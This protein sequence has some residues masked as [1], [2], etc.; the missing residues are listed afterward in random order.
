MVS[1]R[2]AMLLSLHQKTTLKDILSPLKGAYGRYEP[3][4]G[5]P[6]SVQDAFATLHTCC[7]TASSSW[8]QIWNLQ[9]VQK[10]G[11]VWQIRWK[12][13]RPA[14]S[15]LGSFIVSHI[16]AECWSYK[17][18]SSQIRQSWWGRLPVCVPEHGVPPVAPSFSN[19]SAIYIFRKV[20][21]ICWGCIHEKANEHISLSWWT[22][23]KALMA[24]TRWTV[25][26][27]CNEALEE[28]KNEQ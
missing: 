10:V 23:T 6:A 2:A 27:V 8:P 12:S 17:T 14:C 16:G 11:G 24:R 21:A 20:R 5:H 25:S 19:A 4:F 7:S 18:L 26:A 3:G 1:K 15:V 28:V 9:L 13:W 22:Q